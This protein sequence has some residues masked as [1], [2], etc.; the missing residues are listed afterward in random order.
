MLKGK[1]VKIAS[2]TIA[3]QEAKPTLANATAAA[4]AAQ[5]SPTAPGQPESFVF[6]VTVALNVT[7][8]KIDNTIIPLMAGHDGDGRNQNQL[9]P[10]H[11]LP[12]LPAPKI[13]SEALR[14]R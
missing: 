2:G 14:E 7:R 13:A 8:M 5:T 12:A 4:N 10:R 6:R 3:E 9:S 1:V 11:R